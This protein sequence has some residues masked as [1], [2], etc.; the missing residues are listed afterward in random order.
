[1]TRSAP[2][3]FAMEHAADRAPR[4]SVQRLARLSLVPHKLWDCNKMSNTSTADRDRSKSQAQASR[5]SHAR[6]PVWF[7]CCT[8]LTPRLVPALRAR[9]QNLSENQ[10]GTAGVYVRENGLLIPSLC[11]RGP[12]GRG[13]GGDFQTHSYAAARY[14]FFLKRS[15]RLLVAFWT[16]LVAVL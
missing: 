5:S 4:H 9:R 13:E 10:Q 3:T 11:S 2:R 6:A 15:P 8:R 7:V 12:S 14:L 1:M 16:L